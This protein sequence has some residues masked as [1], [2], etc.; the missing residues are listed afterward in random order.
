MGTIASEALVNQ[1]QERSYCRNSEY[2]SIS[3]QIRSIKLRMN[4]KWKVT[5]SWYN[6][7]RCSSLKNTH[8]QFRGAKF[9]TT[10]AGFQTAV[11]KGKGCRKQWYSRLVSLLVCKVCKHEFFCL[12]LR[13]RFGDRL[14]FP[15]VQSQHIEY[16][17]PINRK[18]V[19][20]GIKW[21]CGLTSEL[22][23]EAVQWKGCV[24]WK[25]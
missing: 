20:L 8:E 23:C 15:E 24:G 3:H 19:Y 7:F 12:S 2:R 16:L 22:T 11:S 10:W 17:D 18:S 5:F 25:L 13:P 6:S 4:M 9:L 21:R 1:I 14:Y